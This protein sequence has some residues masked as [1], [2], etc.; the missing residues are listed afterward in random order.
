MID[1]NI[2][3]KQGVIDTPH[4]ARHFIAQLCDEYSMPIPLVYWIPA[5][6]NGEI[7]G[8]YAHGTGEIYIVSNGNWMADQHSIAHEF[9][10]YITDAG[11]S[12]EMYAALVDIAERMELDYTMVSLI[13]LM[14]QPKQ[15]LLGEIMRNR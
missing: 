10:H 11:H 14:Y 7:G 4:R 1:P 8:W 3:H 15:F 5:E 13:E 2:L 12:P 6:P 9:A